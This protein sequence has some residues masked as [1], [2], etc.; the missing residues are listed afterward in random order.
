MIFQSKKFLW[1]FSKKW[2]ASREWAWVRRWLTHSLRSKFEGCC[3]PSLTDLEN[4]SVLLT[5]THLT[6]F[7][8]LFGTL[9]FVVS[10]L[11]EKMTGWLLAWSLNSGRL[12]AI[13]IL[14]FPQCNLSD[15]RWMSKRLTGSQEISV[16]LSLPETL[17]KWTFFWIFFR[18]LTTK[19]FEKAIYWSHNPQGLKGWA[20]RR[21][22]GKS[23]N[24][25]KTTI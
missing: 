13:V 4:L 22:L 24:K 12:Q 17:W 1:K 11:R 16:N 20:K 21:R 14:T 8:E 23:A 25:K 15:N 2:L 18:T 5:L 7:W 3:S 6:G 9:N 10:V 19:L